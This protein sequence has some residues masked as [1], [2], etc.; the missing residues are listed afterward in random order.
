MIQNYNTQKPFS[1]E[2]QHLRVFVFIK[3][4]YSTTMRKTQINRT[5]KRG[6]YQI[7]DTAVGG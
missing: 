7:H 5:T 3:E 1:A 2:F 4:L 6:V